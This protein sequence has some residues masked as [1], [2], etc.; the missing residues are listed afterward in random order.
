MSLARRVPLAVA[1][2]LLLAAPAQ[3]ATT[4]PRVAPPIEETVRLSTV[5]K[6]DC[7]AP[8]AG[9]PGVTTRSW[10]A[11]DEGIVAVRLHGPDSSDWDLAL[12]DAVTGRKLDASLAFRSNELATT[13]VVRG[14]H[15]TIQACRRT[16]AD[17]AIPMTIDFTALKVEGPEHPIQLVEIEASS[18]EDFRRIRELGIDTTDHHDGINQDA[19]LH[20]PA[21]ARKL[22]EAGFE[23]RVKIADVVAQDVRDRLAERRAARNGFRAAIPSGRTT[24]RTYDDYLADLKAMV[25]ENPGIVRP[26]TLPK[27]TIDGRDITGVEIATDV[28]RTDDGRP[29]Y[30]QIG[31]HHA[32]EWPSGEATIEFGLD[33]LERGKAGE[34]RWKN[35]LDNARTYVFPIM[36]V[37]GFI[38]SR[39]QPPS[40]QDDL[41]T[42]PGT[43]Q[44]IIGGVGYRRKNCRPLS[45]V[46]DNIP[47]IARQQNDN[48]VDNNRNYGEK[49]G[50]PGTSSAQN[51]LTYHGEGPFS[52]PETQAVR[53]FLLKLQPTVLITNH[54]F[55]GLILRPP[56]TSED[57]P[58]PDEDRMRALGD[59][60]A[61]ETDYTSQ[62]SYQLYDTT[63]TTDDWLYG[64]LSSFSY[65]PEIGK[66]NFHPN[67]VDDFVPEYDGR[68]EIDKETGEPT[69][70]KLGGLREAYLLAGEAVLDPDTHSILRGTAPAGRTLRIKR[71]FVTV[72]SSQP[73]DDGVQNPIQRLD[74]ER[75]TTLIVPADGRFTWHVA[76]STRPFEPNPV[77]W[78]LTCEDGNG[79][80]LEQR[81]VF[82]ARDQVLSLD[83]ACGAAAPGGPPSSDP[84]GSAPPP[85]Q[86]TCQDI[87]RP[88]SSFAAASR[89][90]RRSIDLRGRSADRGCRTSQGVVRAAGLDRVE[91]AVTRSGR[92]GG[93][94][95]CRFL[96][97]DG[98]LGRAGNCRRPKVYLE[99]EGLNEWRY[100]KDVKLRRGR[101]KVW[102]R[103]VDRGGR[104][105]RR[106]ARRNFKRFRVK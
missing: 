79:N 81:E 11:S 59:A 77:P 58:A 36:N 26:V 22:T 7:R 65:T 82:V 67:Y 18:A 87:Y 52:E 23:Y 14:Q 98:R 80:V 74:E 88:E 5:Q 92:K 35:V 63:G 38:T 13:Q 28:N 42:T 41:P 71:R 106:D 57:G 96:G 75:E 20:S 30:V 9:A 40:P 103:G 2:A 102:V 84:P 29:T 15:L 95:R 61:R 104:V 45:P 51:D 25:D 37:D 17:D 12:F 68:E 60:M 53:E 1:A 6:R 66:T 83:L 91:V 10:T 78:T 4:T 73:N 97:E 72:T 101:Y 48:G 19:L 47:C 8:S 90:G 32:R 21:D 100:A 54:T 99:A 86:E 62:Y 69:G 24:Y 89:L 27:K 3:A 94:A 55:T 16:G 49:W 85:D 105:E 64:G 56:G 50:G 93:K 46:E 76:P 33:L 43:P 70:R 44:Q 39:Q 34:P 31:V